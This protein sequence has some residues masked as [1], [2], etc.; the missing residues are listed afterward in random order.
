M[1][2]TPTQHRCDAI[3]SVS[4]Q[5]QVLESKDT[6]SCFSFGAAIGELL[7]RE[8]R[9]RDVMFLHNPIDRGV[10]DVI[11]H[12]SVFSSSQLRELHLRRMSLGGLRTL[13]PDFGSH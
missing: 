11:I 12:F 6:K 10:A 2:S 1:S 5:T 8:L 7:E 4:F 3:L 9:Y 13:A